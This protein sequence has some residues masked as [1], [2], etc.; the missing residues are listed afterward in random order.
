[1]LRR[2]GSDLPSRVADNLF[3]LG[4]YAER[5]EATVRLMRSLIRR[6]EGEA[7]AADGPDIL[8]RL[9]AILAGDTPDGA[10][11]LRIDSPPA[12]I[13]MVGLQ[14]SGKTTT[15]AKIA[16]RLARRDKKKVLLASLD[17]RRPA[18]M[19]QLAVLGRDA[20]VDTLPVVA[21]QLPPQIAKRYCCGAPG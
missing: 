12:P 15:T 21:G 17:T 20:Q 18:A 19:E 1:M 2:S 8:K 13:L 14:G 3:W 4:R 7:G 11:H 5:T 10:A 16:M 9:I 6:M